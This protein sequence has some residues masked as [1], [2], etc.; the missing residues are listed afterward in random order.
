MFTFPRN[1]IA[2]NIRK[3]AMA[4]TNKYANSIKAAPIAIAFGPENPKLPNN[5]IFLI[6]LGLPLF[7]YIKSY[8][9]GR[10]NN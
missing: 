5:A 9:G 10:I 6:L 1:S 3:I 7:Y 2:H 4:S 8:Y